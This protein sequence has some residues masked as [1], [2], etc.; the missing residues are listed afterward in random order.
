MKKIISYILACCI[1]FS[2]FSMSVSAEA[3]DNHQDGLLESIIESYDN[4]FV[5]Y[6][7]GY[8]DSIFDSIYDKEALVVTPDGD[9][10]YYYLQK[11]QIKVKVKENK[12]LPIDEIMDKI[13]QNALEVHSPDTD[14]DNTGNNKVYTLCVEDGMQTEVVEI[15]KK[16]D[17]VESITEHRAVGRLHGGWEC[18]G[19]FINSKN[20]VSDGDI[21]SKYP[22]LCLTA[23]TREQMQGYTYF[24][25][26]PRIST[27]AYYQYSQ[28]TAPNISAA[29]VIKEKYSDLKKLFSDYSDTVLRLSVL[30]IL[31]QECSAQDTVIY[32]AEGSQS[33][34]QPGE[35]SDNEDDTDGQ[36]G[37]INLDEKIDISDLIGLCAHLLGDKK[38]PQTQLK[39]AD[40]NGDGVVDIADLST[41][42]Q[43]IMGDDI[44]LGK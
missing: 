13:G 35:I 19:F 1:C 24:S 39:K 12:T 10:Y 41:L 40:Y 29:T 5:Y 15:L 6:Q 42:K 8:G 21:I 36:T 17:A 14:N 30:A 20:V 22:A 2:A 43:Y 38:I 11:L 26:T 18:W 28:C 25:C 7:N 27:D 34:T 9:S 32:K 33:D 4:A 23:D 3:V 31:P 44:K 37:D 16:Y